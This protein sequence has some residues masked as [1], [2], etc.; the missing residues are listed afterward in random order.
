MKN[1]YETIS[2]YGKFEKT[3]VLDVIKNSNPR[4][5]FIKLIINCSVEQLQGLICEK[6]TAKGER[7]LYNE[8]FKRKIRNQRKEIDNLKA[9]VRQMEI[10]KT[11]K[12]VFSESKMENSGINKELFY[13]TKL[14]I[15]F[16]ETER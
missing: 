15:P 8:A 11:I 10:S 5:P 14:G 9:Q 6:C 12:E 7:I 1:G 4:D 3:Y 2:V 13:N 16:N